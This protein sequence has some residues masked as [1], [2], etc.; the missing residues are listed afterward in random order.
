[1]A[2]RIVGPE[3]HLTSERISAH[4]FGLDLFWNGSGIMSACSE[5]VKGALT[6]I[7]SVIIGLLLLA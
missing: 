2:Q 4:C 5:H 7:H 3:E 1:M 6:K